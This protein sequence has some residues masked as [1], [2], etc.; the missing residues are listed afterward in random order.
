[1][2]D[3]IKKYLDERAAQDPQFAIS[4][5]KPNKNLDECVQ[6]IISQARKQI[7]GTSGY[8][9]NEEVFGW[10]VHYYDEDNLKF[11]KVSGSATPASSASRV[12]AAADKVE[13]TAEE[14]ERAHKIAMERAIE[15]Q[16][17]KMTER[18]AK[19]KK[20]EAPQPEQMSLFE[21]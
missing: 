19:A 21:F 2:K 16:R 17:K 18:K 6:Y 10:A 11:T 15:E 12:S 7:T 13:L 9:K 3:I 5:A 4:Y 14:K 8:V 1:M 20:D